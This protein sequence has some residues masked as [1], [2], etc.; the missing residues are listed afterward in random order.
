MA[1]ALMRA[2]HIAAVR[3]LNI[4]QFAASRDRCLASLASDLED[5]VRR[6]AATAAGSSA[7]IPFRS[8]CGVM[9]GALVRMKWPSPLR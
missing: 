9:P 3:Q 7:V 4:R 2:R 6:A 1:L 5:G 8:C